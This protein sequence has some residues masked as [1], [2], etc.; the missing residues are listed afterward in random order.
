MG[1]ERMRDVARFC[2]WDGRRERAVS[3][4]V[5]PGGVACATDTALIVA[6]VREVLHG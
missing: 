2:E 1:G 5:T 3:Y 6:M 4:V